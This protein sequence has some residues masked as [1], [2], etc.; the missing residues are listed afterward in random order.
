MIL[1]GVKSDWSAVRSGVPQSSVLGPILFLVYIDD[2]DDNVTSR[3]YKFADDI[4]VVK[5]ISNI[6]DSVNL[7]RDLDRITG[8]AD[9]W[10]IEFSFSKCS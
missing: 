6:E 3:L 10:Q 2:I 4:K 5:G 1:S 7:Q 9:N 8:W